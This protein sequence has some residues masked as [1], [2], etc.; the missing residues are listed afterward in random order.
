MDAEVTF[1]VK[2][3]GKLKRLTYKSITFKFSN[4]CRIYSPTFTR[5]ETSCNWF[6]VGKFNLTQAKHSTPLRVEIRHY[7][8]KI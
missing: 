5:T 2:R 8:C 6:I 1:V 4:N 3:L 7:Y